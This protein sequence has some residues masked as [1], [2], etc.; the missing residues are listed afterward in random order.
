[1]LKQAS[2]WA[3]LLS[4]LVVPMSVAQDWSQFRGPNASGIANEKGLP[5]EFGPEKNVVWKTS[6]PAGHSSPVLTKDRIFVTAYEPSKLYVISLNR[7][8]GK[9]L[10]RREVPKDRNQELHK[11]NSPASPSVATDGKNVYAFFT[12]FGLICFDIDGKEQWRLPLGPFNNPFGMGASPILADDKV[13]LNCDSESGSFFIAV[14]KNTGKVQW[15]VERPEATRGF[16][17]PLLFKPA[18]APLQVLVAGSLRLSAYDV[19]TG[20]EVWWL[21][22]LTWQLKPTPVLGQNRLFVLGWAGGADP[23]QQE[24]IPSFAEAL[25]QF[26]SNQDG[27]IA[28][29]EMTNPQIKRAWVEFDLDRDGA[30]GERDWGAYQG[31]KSVING[32]LAFKLDPQAELRGDM[33]DTHLLWRYEKSLPNA[34]SPLFYQDVVYL[35]KEGGIL[36]ALDAVTGKLLKQG[37]L[38]GALGDYYASP[39]A[40]DGKVFTLSE[41]GKLTVLKAGGEWEIL[42]VNDLGEPAHATPA[43]A[44]GKLYVRTHKTLFCFAKIEPVVSGKA[45]GLE[46]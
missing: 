15:R 13:L 40:A 38:M 22:G 44:D 17:T 28:R 26:D 16:S 11:S 27:R 30:L 33:T 45:T 3:L 14:D 39:V 21:R 2:G 36:S 1:V 4:C 46:Q 25:K 18:K 41:E 24:Q 43:I 7:A 12:D 29:D 42:A 9:I 20:K 31:R 6:L 10:W 32:L 8:D 35:M 19:A 34:P 5:S 37:R 23:G